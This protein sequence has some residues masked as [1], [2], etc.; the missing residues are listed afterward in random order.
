MFKK[1]QFLS[2]FIFVAVAFIL[3]AIYGINFGFGAQCSKEG[4]KKNSQ[5]WQ[6]CVDNLANSYGYKKNK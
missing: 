1:N 2:A 5:S 6:E 4:H 3:C